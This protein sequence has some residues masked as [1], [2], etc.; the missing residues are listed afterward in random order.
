MNETTFPI[1]EVLVSIVGVS[2]AALLAIVFYMFRDLG[3]RITAI[4]SALEELRKETKAH[5]DELRK[6]TK[7]HFDELRKEIKAHFDKFNA[8]FDKFND[9]FYSRRKETSA[10]SG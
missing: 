1:A 4:N 3:K 8:H 5:F 7:A 10:Q 6:E 2:A 9:Y